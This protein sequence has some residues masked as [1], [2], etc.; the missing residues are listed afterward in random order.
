MGDAA[1]NLRPESLRPGCSSPISIICGRYYCYWGDCQSTKLS[2]LNSLIPE[3]IRGVNV[4]LL[5]EVLGD[6]KSLSIP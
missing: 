2:F 5:D 4:F 6:L 1:N 3:T